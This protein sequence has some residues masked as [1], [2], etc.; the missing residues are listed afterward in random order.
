MMR[1][2]IMVVALLFMSCDECRNDMEFGIKYKTVDGS[3]EGPLYW[4][5]PQSSKFSIRGDQGS[6][7]LVYSS[8]CSSVITTLKGATIDY[9]VVSKKLLYDTAKTKVELVDPDTLK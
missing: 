8:A 1:D 9:K 7:S 3:W 6:Y 4:D 5:L 2:V